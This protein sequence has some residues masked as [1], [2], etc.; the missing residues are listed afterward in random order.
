MK[1]DSLE[2]AADLPAPEVLALEIAE[3]LAAAL[4]EINAIAA[5]LGGSEA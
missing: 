4:A 5:S 2:D 3:E 1:D